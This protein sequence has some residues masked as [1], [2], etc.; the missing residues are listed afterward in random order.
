MNLNDN[1][2]ITFESSSIEG[3]VIS[4]NPLIIENQDCVYE[5]INLS[6]ILFI[7]V[8]KK[9]NEDLIHEHATKVANEKIKEIK[10]EKKKIKD[11]FSTFEKNEDEFSTVEDDVILEKE[12]AYGTPNISALKIPKQYSNKKIR[13][14]NTRNKKSE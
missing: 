9:V 14:K 13:I 5:N 6:K 4:I 7:K 2:K 11:L 12:N 3:K 10:I 1:I 8:T